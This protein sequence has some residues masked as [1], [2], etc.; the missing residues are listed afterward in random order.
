[1]KLR[2]CLPLIIVFFLV[3]C[4]KS[5]QEQA[6]ELAAKRKAEMQ[7]Y[8]RAFKVAVMPTMD[9]L[10]AFI[11]KDSLLYDTTKVDIRLKLFHAQI[12]CDTAMA[13]G[14]VQAAFTDLIRAERLRLR[15]KV[16]LHFLTS[17]NAHWK[18]IADRQSNIK[19]P[20]D[21]SDHI[22]AMT[23]FSAIDFLTDK[24][25]AKAKPKYKVFRVQVNDVFVRLKMLQNHEI[26]AYWFQ[27]PQATR[28]L[29]GD[30]IVLYNSDESDYQ[31]GVV[32][33]MDKEDRSAQETEFAKAYNKAVERLNE[34]GV[35]YYAALIKKYMGASD[36]D[37]AA[38]PD[39]KYKKVERPMQTDRVETLRYVATIR[40]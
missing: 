33:V 6:A 35:K 24:V 20:A 25:L 30:N 22:V 38:L 32:A 13:G 9:C 11:L 34:H 16:L 36:A 23:R 5:S 10:P 2:F 7:A 26:D 3:G 37:I 15:K 18:L 19:K 27:E 31:L 21:L 40:R 12:D 39:I 1:M 4:G 28:A 14:S 8:H 17:T 29:Q